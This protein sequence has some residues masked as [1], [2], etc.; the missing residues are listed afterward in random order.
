VKSL[1]H[2]TTSRVKTSYG[3]TSG[4]TV[5]KGLKQSSCM[6][7]TLFKIYLENALENWKRKCNNMGIPV[8]DD[9]TVYTLSFADDQAVAAQDIDDIEY[10][11]RKLME[12]YNKWGL[13]VNIDKTEYMCIGGQ[14]QDLRLATGH[15]I[16]HCSEYKYL[17]VKIS[18]AGT[19]DE[20]IA[21]RN[22]QARRAISILNNT[23]W[24]KN[25][26]TNNKKTNTYTTQ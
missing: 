22:V 20:A 15:T 21:E 7:P 19:L 9:S 16:K 5:T 26:H 11:T 2:G 10:M 1:Y 25:I 8:D 4:F 14:Q 3:L 6:S 13:E 18:K 12:E 24:N 23:L 17:G